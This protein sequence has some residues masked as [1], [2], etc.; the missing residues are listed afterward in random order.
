MAALKSC[1][2]RTEGMASKLGGP[3]GGASSNGPEEL[4]ESLLGFT[5]DTQLRLEGLSSK[6]ADPPP[7]G[8]EDA[9]RSALAALGEETVP[10]ASIAELLVQLSAKVAGLPADASGDVITAAR[11]LCKK[12]N[13]SVGQAQKDD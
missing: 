6:E 11:T 3:A 5:P 2:E 4:C 8:M 1:L 13:Q 10:G 9:L 12:A 7:S